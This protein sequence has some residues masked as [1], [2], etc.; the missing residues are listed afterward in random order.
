[1][2]ERPNVA[3]VMPCYKSRARVMGVIDRIG[4]EAFLIIVIDDGCPEATGDWV[5]S[6]TKDPRVQ[7]VR[8]T[9]NLGVG[10]AVLHGYRVALERGADIVVKID[11][12]GQM[13]PA[14]LPRIIHPI[15][16][17][18]AD[19]TKGNRFFNVDDVRSMPALRLFGNA[20]L[21]FL[22]KLSSGYWNIFDPTNGYIAIHRSALELLPLEKIDNGFFFES[23]MLFRL[24]LAAAVV[25]DVP[26]R[27]VYGN[28]QSALSVRKAVLPF[29]FK[30]IANAAKRIV[31]RYFVR[32]MNIGSLE[33]VAGTLLLLFGIV[34]GARAWIAGTEAGVFA[35]PG[36]VMLAALPVLVGIQFIL[37]FFAFD[38][39]AV[40]RVPLQIILGP[41]PAEPDQES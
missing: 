20:S 2:S 34:F 5:A 22:T 14:L 32:D 26:M 24:Y 23:D 11:S 31:Y 12:D 10:G 39:A 16:E 21:S 30:N 9:S 27:A 36:T 35:S 18:V 3:V 38:V 33:L 28:E 29:A 13:D 15:L 7:V 17:R 25:V 6:S 37:G 40:P 1:M 19:Y 4:P 8:N 41:R